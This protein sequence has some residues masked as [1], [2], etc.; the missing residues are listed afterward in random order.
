[1]IYECYH[2]Y[3]TNVNVVSTQ[4]FYI[5]QTTQTLNDEIRIEPPVFENNV[6]VNSQQFEDALQA[7]VEKHSKSRLIIHSYSGFILLYS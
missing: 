4:R 3:F 6:I 7:Y 5:K 2:A 1:M